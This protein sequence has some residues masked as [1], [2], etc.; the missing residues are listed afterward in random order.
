MLDVHS[1]AGFAKPC[2][3][4]NS[5][6]TFVLGCPLFLSLDVL[7]ASLW[8]ALGEPT[9]VLDWKANSDLPI[10]GWSLRLVD[11]FSR[12]PSRPPGVLTSG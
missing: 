6:H 2:V 8:D 12:H 9:L 7:I 1:R 10:Y 4:S 11:T 3:N 5:A